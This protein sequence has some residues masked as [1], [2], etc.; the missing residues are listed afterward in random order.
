[1]KKLFSIFILTMMILAI[2][3][4]LIFA[5]TAAQAEPQ[6]KLDTGDT[7]WMIVQLLLLC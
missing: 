6:P 5:E 4:N 2:S 3:M 7:A 1:M